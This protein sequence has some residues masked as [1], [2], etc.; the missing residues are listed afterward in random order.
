MER[1][2]KIRAVF[3][4]KNLTT[5]KPE[6]FKWVGILDDWQAAWIIED[7]DYKGQWAFTPMNRDVNY[8][9]CWVPEEDLEVK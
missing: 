4:P 5:L 8:D 9:F 2:D 1:F 7:G 3:K 6:A